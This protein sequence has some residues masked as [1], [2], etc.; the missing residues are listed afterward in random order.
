MILGPQEYQVTSFGL[1]GSKISFKIRIR[2]LL[3][4]TFSFDK[5]FLTLRGG[6]WAKARGSLAVAILVHA[7]KMLLLFGGA[8]NEGAQGKKGGR[9]RR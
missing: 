1:A 4:E 2:Q 3:P 8:E 7:V 9:K 6:P 5:E